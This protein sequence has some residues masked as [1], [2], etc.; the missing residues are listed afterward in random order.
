MK[1]WILTGSLLCLLLSGSSGYA[2]ELLKTDPPK[3]EEPAKPEE[4]KT[5][6]VKKKDTQEVIVEC[7]HA[8]PMRCALNQK[9]Q[10]PQ[11]CEALAKQALRA[12]DPFI[13][14]TWFM[15]DDEAVKKLRT[16]RFGK[17]VD[18]VARAQAECGIK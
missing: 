17:A 3:A 4:P 9:F 2:E 10:V 18:V 16:E 8:E 13:W 6:T 11:K 7:T 12:I 14:P 5:W 1:L 15:T